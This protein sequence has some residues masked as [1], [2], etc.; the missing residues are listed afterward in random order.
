MWLQAS[1]IFLFEEEGKNLYMTGSAWS[2]ASLTASNIGVA[3][4]ENESIP[5]IQV[6]A[7]QPQTPYAPSVLTLDN[8]FSEI[9][10]AHALPEIR[11]FD[12]GYAHE[13]KEVRDFCPSC[14]CRVPGCQFIQAIGRLG[15][16]QRFSW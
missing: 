4:L 7:A 11:V 6:D 15:L 5:S 10:P 14:V 2:H 8:G 9:T 3:V 12:F 1:G 16:R 13:R